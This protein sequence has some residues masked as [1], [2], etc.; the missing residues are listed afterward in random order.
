MKKLTLLIAMLMASSAWGETTRVYLECNIPNPTIK[1]IPTWLGLTTILKNGE[2]Y[3]RQVKTYKGLNVEQGED[4]LYVSWN[5][6]RFWWKGYSLNRETLSLRSS[7][8]GSS[9]K[10][11]QC[12]IYPREEWK[13]RKNVHLDS[14]KK[15]N[16]L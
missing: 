4:A 5:E 15:R 7:V 2:V 3:S 10:V 8:Y 1:Q 9:E 6:I 11:K 13:D 12:I 16:K 14:L